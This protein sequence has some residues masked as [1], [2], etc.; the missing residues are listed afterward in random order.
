MVCGE[1]YALPS[2]GSKSE[3]GCAGKEREGCGAQWGENHMDGWDS[4]R[5]QGKCISIYWWERT[6]EEV[7]KTALETRFFNDGVAECL[8]VSVC[9]HRADG[10]RQTFFT[11]GGGFKKGRFVLFFGCGRRGGVVSDCACDLFAFFFGADLVYE[12]GHDLADFFGSAM[13]EGLFYVDGVV[14]DLEVG[15]GG[16]GFEAHGGEFCDFSNDGGA[17]GFEF[18]EGVEEGGGVSAF[19]DGAGNVDDLF[20]D[21]LFFGFEGGEAFGAVG[22]AVVG[23]GAGDFKNGGKGFGGEDV[24]FEGVKDGLFEFVT[25]EARGGAIAFAAGA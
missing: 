18:G 17:A 25:G 21:G 9:P 5:V 13:V 19:G 10:Y 2:T 16:D 12:G 23:G 11:C 15:E 3:I 1:C 20:G 6:E 22:F 7:E 8:P 4:Q 14:D 24:F